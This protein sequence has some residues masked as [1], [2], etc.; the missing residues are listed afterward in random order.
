[1]NWLHSFWFHYEWSSDTGNGPEAITELLLGAF[2][3]SFFIPR[4]RKWWARH[5]DDLKSH[6]S[7]ENKRLHAKMDHIIEHHPDIP[8]F[9]EKPHE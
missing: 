6:V 4:V 9:K 3:G 8:D 5:I 7:S 1:M 2:I